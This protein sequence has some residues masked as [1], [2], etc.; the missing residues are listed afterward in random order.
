MKNGCRV[1]ANSTALYITDTTYPSNIT[2]SPFTAGPAGGKSPGSPAI[3]RFDLDAELRPSNKT[4][5]ALPSRGV[6][7]GIHIDDAERI[8]TGEGDGVV[9]RNSAGTILGVFNKEVL[10]EGGADAE[11]DIANICLAGD[12]LVIFALQRLW[13][14]QLTESVISPDRYSYS[15]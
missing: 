6:P 4:L 10:L 7:D 9:V 1:N 3:Y 11:Y 14:V 8:W 15:S 13:L 2:N 5:V 12:K